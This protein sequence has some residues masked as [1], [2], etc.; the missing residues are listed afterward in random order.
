MRSQN[1][2]WKFGDE[3]PGSPPPHHLLLVEGGDE[4]HF[5]LALQSLNED[6]PCF[7]V[8][9]LPGT[10]SVLKQFAIEF[11]LD[12]REAVGIVIDANGNPVR[13]WEEIIE[14]LPNGFTNIPVSPDQSGTILTRSNG[15][16]FGV[17]L[18]PDNQSEGELEHFI[19]RLMFD[20][21]RVWDQAQEY[22]DNIHPDDQLFLE[23]KRKKAEVRAWLAV[24][25][26]PGLLGEAV[27]ANDL[28][29]DAPLAK[30]FST[31]LSELFRNGEDSANS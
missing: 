15:Q 1:S 9:R 21:D 5:I 23:E 10:E 12:E 20:K 30:I 2:N 4:R 27:Q 6:M 19:E 31:W 25:E 29:L 3:M 18:M 28:N 8:K 26:K 17:W 7:A 13:R 16:R 11:R 22:V 14:H 24:R